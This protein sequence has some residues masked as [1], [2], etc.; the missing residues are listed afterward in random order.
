MSHEY[1]RRMQIAFIPAVRTPT[2]RSKLAFGLL[3]AVI[4]PMTAILAVALWPV[5]VG[6]V[7]TTT[8][9]KLVSHLTTPRCE[10]CRK[11]APTRYTCRTC[12]R[13][14]GACCTALYEDDAC[15]ECA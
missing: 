12:G 4:A 6:I 2:P 14:C 9:R 3:V 10:R 5:T 8:L 1:L 13:T 11:P 15:V 7:L